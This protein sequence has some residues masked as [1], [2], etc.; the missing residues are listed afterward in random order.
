MSPVYDPCSL[1][2][3][4]GWAQSQGWRY[5]AEHLTRAFVQSFAWERIGEERAERVASDASM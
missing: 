5:S 4:H 2:F 3:L 1:D